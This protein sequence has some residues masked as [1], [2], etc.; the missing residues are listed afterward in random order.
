VKAY[1]EAIEVEL[2][3]A[4]LEIAVAHREQELQHYRQ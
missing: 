3:L 2:R 4:E 1:L